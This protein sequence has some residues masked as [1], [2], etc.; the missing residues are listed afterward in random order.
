MRLL[1]F[2][3]ACSLA[4]MPIDAARA[5][6]VEETHPVA[7]A[8]RLRDARDFRAAIVA[9][10]KHL[11]EHPY[12]GDAI[13]MYAQT[14]YWSGE[15]KE[16]EAVYEAALVRNSEDR[17]LRLDFARMLMETR[18]VARARVLL[19]P[20]RADPHAAAEAE[21]LLGSIAYWQG[22]LTA[23]SRHFERALR[24]SAENGEAA[25]QLGEIRTLAAPW[26]RLGGE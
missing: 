2:A 23:A 13:R 15:V 19:T 12:D 20:L 18:R 11:E 17:R 8:A 26:L 21:S 4:L 22:D 14:L 24:L 10:R 6:E 1:F 5:Q 3:V 16:A 7:E 9:L 25:R